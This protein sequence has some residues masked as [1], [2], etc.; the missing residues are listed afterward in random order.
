MQIIK[1]KRLYVL[2]ILPIRSFSFLTATRC[3][4][5]ENYYANYAQGNNIVILFIVNGPWGSRFL[6]RHLICIYI[7]YFGGCGGATT[8]KTMTIFK[9]LRGGCARVPSGMTRRE[10]EQVWSDARRFREF[11]DYRLSPSP[12]RRVCVRLRVRVLV[13]YT[14]AARNLWLT[15]NRLLKKRKENLVRLS[16]RTRKRIWEYNR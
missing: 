5:W 8:K 9:N 6:G 13:S 7:Y 11:Y 16:H 14:A 2:A 4:E 10:W 15:I 1:K 12:R 3:I